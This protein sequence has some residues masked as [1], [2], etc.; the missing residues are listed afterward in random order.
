MGLG[1]FITVNARIN[2]S[3]LV[4]NNKVYFAAEDNYL[5]ALDEKTGK[6]IWDFTDNTELFNIS[7]YKNIIYTHD[8]ASNIY[9]L[10]ADTGKL[11][12]KT[13]GESISDNINFSSYLVIAN[14]KVYYVV[15]DNSLIARDASTGNFMGS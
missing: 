1:G 4:A 12:W 15:E 13:T 2:S 8:F 9:A 14:D 3:P 11:I 6:K 5:Y 10:D 7:F